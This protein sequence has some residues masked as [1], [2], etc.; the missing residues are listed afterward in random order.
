MPLGWTVHLAFL[1][2]TCYLFY[3]I[4]ESPSHRLAR[5]LSKQLGSALSKRRLANIDSLIRSDENKPDDDLALEPAA[6]EHA[7]S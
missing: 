3:L 7:T 4:I 2:A 6:T 1:L 5:Q